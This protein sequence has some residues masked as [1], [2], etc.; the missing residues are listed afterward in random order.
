MNG[1]AAHVNERRSQVIKPKLGFRAAHIRDRL[2]RLPV[3]LEPPVRI[4]HV[5]VTETPFLHRQTQSDQRPVRDGDLI[6]LR[7]HD[8]K[9]AGLKDEV[10]IRRLD[11]GKLLLCALEI[12]QQIRLATPEAEAA[13]DELGPNVFEH[14]DVVI[15]VA[16]AIEQPF[17]GDGAREEVFQHLTRNAFVERIVSGR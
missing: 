11:L 7:R 16:P 13:T 10:G 17:H 2:A 14:S 4:E 1:L 15:E 3:V 8:L 9:N 5:S 12:G 6:H